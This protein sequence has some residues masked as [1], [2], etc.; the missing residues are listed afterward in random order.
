MAN[1]GSDSG[2]LL[3]IR[4]I[5]PACPSDD[6]EAMAQKRLE[7]TDVETPID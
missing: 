7:V 2:H 5:S 4:Q 3:V 6:P 1:G